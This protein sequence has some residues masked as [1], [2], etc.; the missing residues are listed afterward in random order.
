V[1]IEIR[2]FCLAPESDEATFLR[3]DEVVQALLSSRPGFVR[4]TTAR[5]ARQDR[6][7][8]LE[9]LDLT[10]WASGVHA[11]DAAAIGA[12]AHVDALV[13]GASVRVERYESLD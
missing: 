2:T 12:R 4:R 9:W 8:G 6:E 10:F 1:L 5:Q 13:D 7:P 3:A 11:D